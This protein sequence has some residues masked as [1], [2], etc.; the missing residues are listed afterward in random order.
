MRE[1]ERR[2]VGYKLT[3]TSHCFAILLAQELLLQNEMVLL[4]ACA[5]WLKN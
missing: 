5:E 2:W 1:L 3:G 4:L